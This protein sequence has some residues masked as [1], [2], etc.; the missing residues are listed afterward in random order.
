[1]FFGVGYLCRI[2]YQ[3]G[4]VALSEFAK[5][6]RD[7]D[8][9][10]RIIIKK[11]GR[12]IDYQSHREAATDS[13]IACAVAKKEDTWYVSVGARSGKAEL[14]V[15]QQQVTDAGAF[16]KEIISEYTFSSNMRGSEAYRRH[17]AEVYTKRQWKKYCKKQ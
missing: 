17:L 12:K 11:D 5:M 13:V 4:V 7:R 2:I 6:P 16:A 8:I 10:V 1:M 3:A 15:R 9:S 14:S